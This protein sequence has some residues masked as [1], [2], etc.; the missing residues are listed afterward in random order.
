[1]AVGFS[2]KYR[3]TKVAFL[4]RKGH[5][6]DLVAAAGINTLLWGGMY[7]PIIPIAPKGEDNSIALGLLNAFLP[8]TLYNVVESE[9]IKE[10]ASKFTFLRDPGHYADRIFHE[11]WFSKKN[12]LSYLDSLNIVEKLWHS[13]FK[14][15]RKNYRS[16][17]CLVKWDETDPLNA[18]FSLN[19]GYFPKNFNLKDD[20]EDAFVRGLRSKKT[21]LK[22]GANL[23]DFVSTSV[24][25]LSLT[26]HELKGYGG[27]RQ[28]GYGVYFGK[29]DSFEDLVNFWNL[30]ASGR[31]LL[32]CPIDE[33]AR[34]SNTLKKYLKFL[35]SIPSA[36]PELTEWIAVYHST[37]DDQIKKVLEAFPTKKGISFGKFDA[38]V[39]DVSWGLRPAYQ[40]FEWQRAYGHVERQFDRYQVNLPLPEKKFL[41][42]ATERRRI[43]QQI[44]SVNISA[45]GD[46]GFPDHTLKIPC[47]PKL[48]EF[49]SR[50][51]IFDPWKL[52]V[53]REGFSLVI[54]VN[55]EN[56]TLYPIPHQK[57]L[58]RILEYSDI[59]TESNQAG[60]LASK[61]ITGMREYMPLEACRVF[62]ITGVRK[63]LK[64]LPSDSQIKWNDAL[65]IIWDTERFKQFQSLFLESRDSKNLNP[66]D[67]FNFLVKKNI[68]R[69]KLR[70]LEKILRRS[71]EYR[72]TE[73]GLAATVPFTD[74]ENDKWQCPYCDEIQNLRPLI[75]QSFRDQPK[76]WNF[77]KTGLFA[78]N[79]NQEGA[80][81][82][83]LTLLTFGRVFNH[84]EFFYSTA[85]NMKVG[86]KSFESDFV[87]FQHS[88]G[89]SFEVGIG[90]AKDE[91]GEIDQN[92]IDN[93]KLAREKLVAKGFSCYLIFAKTADG[94]TQAELDR[95]RTLESEHVPFI[96]F[97]NS[98]LEPYQPYW[99]NPRFKEM[100]YQY[101][102]RMSE[103]SINSRFLYLGSVQGRNHG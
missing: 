1:M 80:I 36:R 96:L 70:W 9:E 22:S 57:L 14:N 32:F 34:F 15:K 2:I 10:F 90:E 5:V 30:R 73:C 16:N 103:M 23:K 24:S 62:K 20:F 63:L 102:L 19:F 47:L 17:C 35:D 41:N 7:N 39:V 71:K 88:R 98:E 74:F 75:V 84:G 93:L 13:E 87:V 52:R 8:D 54:N 45:H 82:V 53:E 26:N 51:I 6:E 85:L 49:Y 37:T 33:I 68:L 40:C 31:M 43:D 64:G 66:R 101:A 29:K 77:E 94:F 25:P 58:E 56:E 65:R 38:D 48:N 55:D 12:E 72:C 59:K 78:K 89:D 86:G 61:I 83:I 60:R 46:F 18:V 4:V 76:I 95:F 11:E 91:G 97:S 42:G 3:P 99:E 67:A 28:D 21:E 79:N 50:E 100:P 69:P 44:L 81:P 92:D 27:P